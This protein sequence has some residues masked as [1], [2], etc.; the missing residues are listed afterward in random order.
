VYPLTPKINE[1]R[2]IC[3]ASPVIKFLEGL[4]LKKLKIYATNRLHKWQYGFVPG[5]SIDEC[6]SDIITQINK[7]LQK[8]REEPN[9]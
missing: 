2:P 1:Y 7:H 8:I 9:N 5:V 3:V 6:K 4:L